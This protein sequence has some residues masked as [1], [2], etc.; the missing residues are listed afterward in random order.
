MKKTRYASPDR[1]T[2]WEKSKEKQPRANRTQGVR[3]KEYSV[4]LMG[5]M[6]Q[7]QAGFLSPP[8]EEDLLDGQEHDRQVHEPGG[9]FDI[10]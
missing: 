10:I 5:I 9:V 7:I 3:G 2:L 1:Y 8:G 6:G 4:R